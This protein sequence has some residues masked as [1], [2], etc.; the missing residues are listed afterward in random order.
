MKE[1]CVRQAIFACSLL[2]CGITANAG[3][4][5]A[6]FNKG[7]FNGNYETTD[8]MKHIPGSTYV[9]HM[10]IPGTHDTATGEGFT[11]SV[12][13]HSAQTQNKTIVEQINAGIRAIDL[14]P[15]V[16]SGTLKCCH[17]VAETTKTVES[18]IDDLKNFLEAHPTEFFII[19]MLKADD[20]DNYKTQIYNFFNQDKYA[21][22]FINFRRDLTVDDMRGKI[23]VFN[24]NDDAPIPYGGDLIWWHEQGYNTSENR[25]EDA[26]VRSYNPSGEGYGRLYTQDVAKTDGN[27]LNIKIEQINKLIDYSIN[28]D[29]QY[30]D[31][32][33]WFF[34]FTSAYKGSS[35]SQGR[36]ADNASY[37]NPTILNRI[38]E[39]QGTIG[40]VLMDWACN[41]YGTY[42]SILS[43]KI[44]C[45]VKSQSL[46][47][48]LIESNFRY[49]G[50]VEDG[51]ENAY[52]RTMYPMYGDLGPAPAWKPADN[53]IFLANRRGGAVM[54]D[55][56]NND[57]LDIYNSG[58]YYNSYYDGS[59]WSWQAQSNLYLNQGGGK[60]WTRD[61]ISNTGQKPQSDIAPLVF[62]HFATLDYNNDGLVDLLVMGLTNGDDW[63]NYR[64]RIDCKKMKDSDFYA[65][66]ILYRNTGGGKFE[67]ETNFNVPTYYTRYGDRNGLMTTMHPIAV[68]DFDR[69]GFV[70]I[71]V[72]GMR[73]DTDHENSS[74]ADGVQESA[75]YRNING[76]GSFERVEGGF[77][78]IGG[79]AYMADF[80]N[81]GWL[82]L[83]FTGWGD[84]NGRIYR[85]LGGA[86]FS[87]ITGDNVH[88]TRHGSD[89]I[90]DFNNDG[91]LDFLSMGWSDVRW[92]Y[93]SI[94]YTNNGTDIPFDLYQD[95]NNYCGHADTGEPFN[96]YLG[97]YNGDGH[98]DIMYDGK[99]DD[100]TVLG[101]SP[102]S[103]DGNTTPF[104][105]RGH[106]N[107]QD[108]SNGSVA[109][110]D[111]T[112]NGLADRFQVGYNW[113]EEQYRQ[114]LFG[115]DN[116]WVEEHTL[117]LNSEDKTV[118]APD[119]PRNVTATLA[120]GVVTVTW[121]DIDDNSVGYNVVI[122]DSDH[123]MIIANI[124][125]NPA[126]G[127]LR[128]AQ[129]KEVCV[130]PGVRTY[131]V[132][133]GDDA[134]VTGWKAGVQSVSLVNE[135][136]SD[137][138]WDFI[139]ATV[140]SLPDFDDN[141]T[142]WNVNPSSAGVFYPVENSNS[143]IADFNGDGRMDIFNSGATDGTVSFYSN[144]WGWQ[145]QANMYYQQ[146]DGL[147]TRDAI[148]EVPKAEGGYAFD[149]PDHGI[150]PLKFPHFA[151][152]DYNNDGNLDILVSGVLTGNDVT[153][154]K[155][156][157][158]RREVTSEVNGNRATLWMVTLLYRNNGDGTFTYLE[159]TNL[160]VI[161]VDHGDGSLHKGHTPIH[162]PFA[163]GDFNRDGF[164]DIAVS[165]V[166]VVSDNGEE[167]PINALYRNNGDGTFT[168]MDIV[169]GKG[170]FHSVRC[171]NV[172]FADL[173]NDGWL[174]L[175][176]DGYVESPDIDGFNGGSGWRI[177][178]NNKG[179]SFTDVT[180]SLSDPYAA[181]NAGT[182]V[183]DIDGDGFLDVINIG[184]GD[185]GLGYGAFYFRNSAEGGSIF[186]P[187]VDL[188]VSG[189]DLTEG[190]NVVVRDFNGD[191]KLDIAFDGVNENCIYYAG[192]N[193]GY[194]RSQQLPVR[195]N[196]T[197]NNSMAVGDLNGNGLTD[198][199]ETG[200]M[201]SKSEYRTPLSYNE[202]DYTATLW[203]NRENPAPEIGNPHITLAGWIDGKLIV[204]WDDLDDPTVGYN[205]VFR[206]P[207]GKIYSNLPVSADGNI[208][209]SEGKHTAVRPGVGEYTIAHPE[210]LSGRMRST[211]PMP[212]GY[213]I[214]VQAV[215]LVTERVSGV[216]WAD[217]VTGIDDVMLTD[218]VGVSVEGDNVIVRATDDCD[219]KVIDMLGRTVA[220]GVANTP[221]TVAANG[222]F[223]VKT[224]TST[225][226]ISK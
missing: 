189:I 80:N 226:K 60:S 94:L 141:N 159:N 37:T 90:A 50:W 148:E 83:I 63:L 64:D 128:V 122:T 179:V 183:A 195:S 103:F 163:I 135:R 72:S 100:A 146:P 67:L 8:W 21:G 198:R 132:M 166:E 213:Q 126:N 40:I 172:N 25:F 153:W 22:L 155:D 47:Y 38:R 104:P 193:N 95:I 223:I 190:L 154:H 112:G 99:R 174:D 212:S 78:N 85:N 185:N 51:R 54:A 56:D 70:D 71:A 162:N 136:S 131:S 84:T 75:L 28:T 74:N 44:T 26:F 161:Y 197:H 102:T 157:I 214:G 109:L 164:A 175:I 188:S 151:T 225:V 120:D 119:S 137:I 41:D 20:S 61:I 138:I 121:D 181:R 55:F 134:D 17:G 39:K 66:F 204:R 133:V 177:Y 165:G 7:E 3:V 207:D 149:L 221:V 196:R 180:S 217:N 169:E 205:V 184:Y 173:N 171:G 118:S 58:Q 34:N 187:R 194:D 18:A 87:D 105:V 219:V 130:R 191:G 160:P 19:H 145:H 96:I 73:L 114:Q 52:S 93:K 199:F 224:P 27:N 42:G 2:F 16:K 81:D 48:A 45:D 200:Y 139:S 68:G 49:I 53:S 129:G 65:A 9:C 24:R 127:K 218:I 140:E 125:V 13:S 88:F 168:K 89:A 15:A 209:V 167:L 108:D 82:D 79:S 62:P 202:W 210:I 12:T 115:A 220:A 144:V 92:N 150:A 111:V 29:P 110:G 158:P 201:W 186:D 178:I 208:L 1:K 33:E 77:R 35:S 116:D 124:P 203:E 142:T 97:D 211:S 11:V 222:V 182:A 6:T 5:A 101:T 4:D 117:W 152:L 143:I 170:T 98:I 57:W 106:N 91:Y 215:S 76:S 123:R 216:V 46:T 156:R 69:D 14:R 32:C 107:G 206:T 23:L 43:N 147:F 10:S 31:E 86:S 176:F 30:P 36:Y 59:W 192:M 113:C